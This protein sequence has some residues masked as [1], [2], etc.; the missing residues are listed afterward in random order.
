MENVKFGFKV[1]NKELPHKIEECAITDH[2]GNALSKGHRYN[3]RNKSLPNV[4]KAKNAKYLS[5]IFC[6]GSIEYCK[7]PYDI[8]KIRNYKLFTHKCKTMLLE[9]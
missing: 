4:P 7:L 3:T 8:K 9:K 6:Q 1:Q 5:S 2:K